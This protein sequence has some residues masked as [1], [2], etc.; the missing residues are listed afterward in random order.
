MEN[1]DNPGY[2]KHF[3]PIMCPVCGYNLNCAKNDLIENKRCQDCVQYLPTIDGCDVYEPTDKYC[4]C[5][6]H[7][8]RTAIVNLQNDLESLTDELV[9]TKDK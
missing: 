3:I 9:K 4:K 5:T 1:K 2:I 8:L 7:D 6:E